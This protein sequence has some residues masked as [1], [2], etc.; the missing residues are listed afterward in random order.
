M[1]DTDLT[2]EYE[3]ARSI[4]VDPQAVFEAGIAGALCCEGTKERL[5]AISNDFDWAHLPE[6]ELV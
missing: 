2:R 1:F 6:A 5:R 4:D 3:A